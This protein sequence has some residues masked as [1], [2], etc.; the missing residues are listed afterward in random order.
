MERGV[1]SAG[2]VE[3]D[4]TAVGHAPGGA[5][6]LLVAVA[7]LGTLVAAVVVPSTLLPA[8]AG[9]VLDNVAQFVAAAGATAA[10]WTVARR[11]TGIDRTWRRLMGV[12]MAGWA[13]GQL[14]WTIY[15]IAGIQ[16]PPTP[17][18]A[19]AGYLALPIFA[20]LAL[21]AFVSTGPRSAGS[22]RTVLV[23]DGLIVVGSLLALTWSSALGAA[24][25]AVRSNPYAFAVGIAYPLS[26]LGLVVIVILLGATRRVAPRYR[27]QL[28]LVG[29][30]L[31]A[32][33]L[34]DSALAYIVGVSG[35]SI[36]PIAD[37]GF[38][39]GPALVGLAAL[40]PSTEARRNA[41]A[42]PRRWVEWGYLLL[43][44]LP[45]AAVGILIG[46]ETAAGRPLPA[47]QMY[48]AL[49]VATLLAVRQFLTLVENTMLL[50][51]LSDGQRQIA[52]QALHD[53]LTSLANR[54][55][56]TDRLGEALQRHE[57]DGTPV[58]L[59]FIDLDDFK[60]INDSLGHVVGDR[61]LRH[62][63]ER[64]RSCVRRDD[65]V[66]RLGGDE[67]AILLAGAQTPELVGQRVLAALREPLLLDDGT[68]RVSAS[69]GVAIAEGDGTP[70]NADVLLR[71]ADAAMYEG[72]TAGKARLVRYRRGLA[73]D[74][75]D[76]D[77]A[78]LF[79]QSLGHDPGGHGFEVVYS[80]VVRLR[81]GV[82]IALDAAAHWLHPGIGAVD[83]EVLR[84]LAERIGLAAALDNFVLDRACRDSASGMRTD[85]TLGIHV[86]ISAG[87]LGDTAL[88][89]EVAGALQHHRMSPGRLL[90]ALTGAGR[91]ADLTTAAG[92]ARR[93]HD[94]GVRLA[95][96][97]VGGGVDAL[98]ALHTLPIDVVRLDPDLTATEVEP[99]RAEA[100][101][102]SVLTI[103][104]RLGVAAIA[105]GVGTP[106]QADA[107][108]RL[109]IPFAQGDRYG[110]AL[111]FTD[112]VAT[113]AG[114]RP[115]A[116]VPSV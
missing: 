93:L 82:P 1:D 40:R 67:F 18:L 23:L 17:S 110:S 70:L 53:P 44:Y 7:V 90:L 111:A 45:V 39:A 66:A 42:T 88:E 55:L 105:T 8:T 80:P 47:V 103:C 69:V 107:L 36:P 85:A 64:L 71:R 32:L 38:I 62:V 51:R 92:A 26:D 28:L 84:P 20:T 46:V 99:Q 57:R 108:A 116:G 101:C 43:P 81:D 100:I 37:L 54:N 91:V 114:S 48:L 10:C 27:S 96:D 13:L 19:D 16:Q 87:R 5:G 94:L 59:L 77:L 34:S 95:L 74:L 83:A 58:A 112:A 4:A 75:N 49:A 76:P 113:V 97:D 63:G 73:P 102:R 35:R 21:L 25:H 68:V 3:S 56:F 52:H 78:N 9:A 12:G 30:G 24:V 104:A 33:A 61:L 86:A 106:D 31:V 89:H 2:D 6:T 11:T 65:V 109:G 98:A 15:L 79:A 115:A 50:R 14:T 29:L 22:P 60:V 72:K 41:D